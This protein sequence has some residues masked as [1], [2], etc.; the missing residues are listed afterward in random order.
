MHS[1][2]E[3]FDSRVDRLES[4][5]DAV[6]VHFSHG[7]VHRSAGRPGSDPGTGWSQELAIVLHDAQVGVERG[8]LPASIAD[9]YLEVGGVRHDLLPLPF[10]RRGAA[11]LHLVF[12][13]GS[14][15]TVRGRAPVV[16]TLGQPIFLE[17]LR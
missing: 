14:S 7:Y 16:E 4:A 5:A 12:G 13:D 2:L 15:L 11:T 3:L 1:A 9:G 17:N 6:R 10:K 8:T